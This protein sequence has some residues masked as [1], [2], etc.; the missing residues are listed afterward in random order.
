M[1]NISVYLCM[2]C[3]TLYLLLHLLMV[4]FPEFT[5]PHLPNMRLFINF[6]SKSYNLTP[7]LHIVTSLI[8]IVT[9]EQRV[10]CPHNILVANNL[11]NRS[12][13][14]RYT[15]IFLHLKKTMWMKSQTTKSDIYIK[16]RKSTA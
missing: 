15:Q 4:K 3:P 2:F 5:Q 7:D 8:V 9:S 16:Y 12:Q 1:H 10:P 11:P 14:Q 13:Q 6:H